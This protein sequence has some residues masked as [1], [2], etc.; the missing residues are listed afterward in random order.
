[1][2]KIFILYALFNLVSAHAGLPELVQKFFPEEIGVLKRNA[3][4]QKN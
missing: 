4:K 3:Q 1:M 2:K